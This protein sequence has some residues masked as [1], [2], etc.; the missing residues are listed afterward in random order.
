MS[1]VVRCLVALFFGLSAYGAEILPPGFRPTPLGVHALVGAKIVVK[2]GEVIPNGTIIIR[3][4][5]IKAVG[6]DA[7]VPEDARVWDMKGTTIYAGFIDPYIVTGA[8]NASPVSTADSEPI[9]SA[10]LTA[11]GVNFFGA[12]GQSTDRGNA[13]PGYEVAKMT[14]Q[15]R[16]VQEYSP[17]DKSLAALREIGFT[18]GLVAPGK[19]I[20]RGSSALVALSD[21]NP[22]DVILKPDVFQHIAFETHQPGER[23]YPG[24]LMGV[25]ACIRQTFFDA[26]HYALDHA[27]YLKNPQGRKRPEY[28][29]AL[30]ALT[31]VAEKKMRAMFEPGSALMVN[32]AAQLAHELGLDFCIVSC[33]QEWRRPDLAKETDATFIVPLNFP[34]VP[35]M[36][37]ETDWEQVSLDQLRNWDWAPENAAVLREQR[38]EVALT[39]Y[40][41]ADKKKFRQNLKLAVERGLP[42]DDALAALTTIPAK[43][44]GADKQLGSIEAGKLA[45]LTVVQGDNYFNPENKLREVWID[46]RIYRVPPEE[47]KPGKPDDAKPAK[48]VSPEEGAPNRPK[49]E[50]EK[51]PGPKQESTET[52]KEESTKGEKAV[53]EKKD[54][55]KDETKE[56]QKT[57]TARSPMDGRG[58]L[59]SPTSILIR[60]ATIWTCSDKGVLTNASLLI[61]NGKIESVGSV[62]ADPGP[63]TLQIDGQGL[64]VTPGLID[65]HSHTAI[66]G[67]VNEATLPSTAMVR[68]SD[69]VNSETEHI[70]EQLAG[71]LTAANLLHGSANPIGGQN[72]VIKLRYGASPQQMVFEAAPQGIK[73]ALGENVKQSNWGDQNTTRFPQTRMGVRTFIANRFTVAQEYLAEWDKY[74]KTGGVPPRRDLEL[75]AIGEILQGKRWIHCHSYRQDEIL[76]LIRLMENFGVKIGTF[77]HVLEGY[78]IADEIAK[79]GAGGSTFA[80]WW[81]YKFE[82]YDAIPYNGSLMHDRGVLVSFNSDSSELARHL[83]LEAAKAV[84]F[85]DT[86]Q[87]EALKFVTLNPAKQLRIDK[88]VGSLEPGKD[89]DFAIW[90]KAPLDSGT[91]CLQTWIDGKKYFDRSLD[92]ERTKKMEKERAD[93]LAKAK[94]ISKGG[95]GGDAGDKAADTFFQVSLEHQFDGYDRDCMDNDQEEGR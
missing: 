10:S 60:N 3:D 8:S 79:H 93:L 65:C 53:A 26:Q 95:G 71:G 5:L 2:P 19:G 28:D 80:D 57:R 69:V 17:R 87:I 82:V 62:K 13:G 63:D 77:Q 48:P 61:S 41:L 73:F 46:G 70:Y 90:S 14:P 85:G 37:T 43:L 76:T 58:P 34:S 24:S 55:R 16:A 6:P 11:G 35:K 52:K 30:E 44:T 1:K 29:P 54:R 64:H 12:P 9:T 88:F 68:I 91:V 81:A 74:K 15:H 32:R 42:E 39:T 51:K 47:P 31:P 49:G 84:K 66:L 20:I 38:R 45:N 67:A 75:E 27:D 7:S 21:E 92:G 33:G 83:Y 94:K 40:G 50:P 18:A 59:A 72:C 56:L 36:P 78:K 4:G 22:N 86:S 89:A 25:I 23:A